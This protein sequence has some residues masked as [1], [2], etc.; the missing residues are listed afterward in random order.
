MTSYP[1]VYVNAFLY[2]SS[3]TYQRD[4]LVYRNDLSNR[5]VG[6]TSYPL[7]YINDLSERFG[8]RSPTPVIRLVASPPP[9]WLSSAIT[10]T[11]E[12]REAPRREA[13]AAS[14][15]HARRD[16]GTWPAARKSGRQQHWAVDARR[17]EPRASPV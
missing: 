9:P 14:D 3:T 8:V 12:A 4:S 7:V 16:T 11:R 15:G 1:L 6:I 2:F 10:T 13:S 5:V 17:G